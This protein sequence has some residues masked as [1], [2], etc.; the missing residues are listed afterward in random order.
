[1]ESCKSIN[2]MAEM[3]VYFLESIPY[4][5]NVMQ[6][7][8]S[9]SS[10]QST[11]STTAILLIV[12]RRIL[13]FYNINNW[14]NYVKYQMSFERFIS[15]ELLGSIIGVLDIALGGYNRGN[16][17]GQRADIKVTLETG[18]LSA[19]TWENCLSLL[20]DSLTYSPHLVQ[21]AVSNGLFEIMIQLFGDTQNSWGETTTQT[22]I[23]DL[24]LLVL[25]AT[26][27]ANHI[28]TLNFIGIIIYIYIYKYV[29]EEEERE[30][31]SKRWS[32]EV[33][34]EKILTNNENVSKLDLVCEF[35]L[36]AIFRIYEQR[37]N[38]TFKFSCLQA[39][40]KLLNLCNT[41]SISTFI[42]PNLFTHFLSR[43]YIYIY[44]CRNI[45]F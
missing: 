34:K 15:L 19:K 4:L 9:S 38:Y 14:S 22:H 33:E 6:A 25:D 37:V 20:K 24:T 5:C 44:I 23:I 17:L 40:D 2:N 30:M 26:L 27:P 31:E 21:F 36:P 41:E 1:M 16:N 32:I 3:E 18:S 42:T 12:S 28:S 13:N 39:I 11:E 43:R 35:L 8:N 7:Q 45:K 10:K 29:D